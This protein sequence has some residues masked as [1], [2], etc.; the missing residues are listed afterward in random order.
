MIP[1]ASGMLAC[2][3]VAMPKTAPPTTSASARRRPPP[4]R[5]EFPMPASSRF[6]FDALAT[7]STEGGQ[8]SS[9]STDC[10]RRPHGRAL[11]ALGG[12]AF[13]EQAAEDDQ[14]E[15]GEEVDRD[16]QPPSD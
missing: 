7:C 3:P 15:P 5:R 12:S 6:R 11:L 1:L 13:G 14:P 10:A 8:T 16:D 4:S 2:T 9:S